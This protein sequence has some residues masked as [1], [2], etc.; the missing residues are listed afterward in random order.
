MAKL[1]ERLRYIIEAIWKG[2]GATAAASK[3]IDDVGKSAQRTDGMLKQLG[4]GWASLAT[5][6]NQTLE[7]IGKVGQAMKDAWA[8]LGEGAELSRTA[9]IFDNLSASIGTTAD[10]L[11]ENMGEASA[12]MMSNANM[13]A[14]A[15]DI[16]RLGLADTEDQVVR[17][18]NLV[19]RSGWDMQQVIMT[20][21]N[22]SKMRLDA[23]GLSVTDVEDR[24]KKYTDAGMDAS[25]AFDLAVIEAG[26][27]KLLLLGDAAESTTGKMRI[28]EASFADLGDSFQQ[29]VSDVILGDFF[30][31]LEGLGLME[32]DA[33]RFGEKLGGY[34]GKGI[35][36][37]VVGLTL[38]FAGIFAL[39]PGFETL[40]RGL[41]DMAEPDKIIDA[42]AFGWSMDGIAESMERGAAAA[43]KFRERMAG[44]RTGERGG[45][46][47]NLIGDPGESLADLQARL[48]A[49]NAPMR[50][51]I[52]LR[53]EA[54]RAATLARRQELG[55]EFADAFD[56][57]SME[58]RFG[59]YY[60]FVIDKGKQIERLHKKIAE[61]EPGD[62][63]KF[64]KAQ[65]ENLDKLQ[66]RLADVE[67]AHGQIGTGFIP[68]EEMIAGA[69]AMIES[70]AAAGAWSKN[71]Y[72]L[73]G[74]SEAA[75]EALREAAIA[76]HA[77]KLGEAVAAGLMLPQQAMQNLQD[78]ID[79]LS[80]E[81][82]FRLDDSR[83]GAGE[84]AETAKQEMLRVVEGIEPAVSEAVSPA[85]EA[86][87][88]VDEAL[89]LLDTVK[90][91]PEIDDNFDESEERAT[92][93][94]RYWDENMAGGFETT[95]TVHWV[96][97]GMPPPGAPPVDGNRAWGGPVSRGSAYV[98]GEKGPEVFVPGMS[99]W[100]VP[101]GGDGRPVGM[102]GMMSGPV[103]V[104]QN[105]NGLGLGASVAV[106]RRVL[107]NYTRGA[108]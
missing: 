76:T 74:S 54:A 63:G 16:I 34:V 97:D 36:A 23:L 78:F 85:L 22:D 96:T 87:S 91:T 53:D 27:A 14:S 26:E 107:A 20:F 45:L 106:A 61:I 32:G 86:V 94:V 100:V 59:E 98:V 13:M 33:T 21:A 95:A 44:L 56:F 15:S 102:G 93:W 88:E 40:V 60:Q 55:G 10:A 68:D 41:R 84:V 82:I 39:L 101:N 57:D 38:P 92:R 8:F 67:A 89:K 52:R 99:G 80:L 11:L 75:G 108:R 65:L 73:A 17:L 83:V 79:G 103:T 37:G 24:I 28:L 72:E 30:G 46:L 70:A 69:Q 62:D 42:S 43:E 5:P 104:N 29:A 25:K 51:M 49:I 31:V 6:V 66:K 77:Q 81:D 3:G 105:F 12:G 58:R 35:I 64:T 71:L 47:G 2:D 1:E 19:A 48:E 4:A 50:E 7:I 18:S 9:E 90:S